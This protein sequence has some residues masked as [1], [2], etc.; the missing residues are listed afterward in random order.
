MK[1]KRLPY[2]KTEAFHYVLTYFENELHV[3]LS[4]IAKAIYE[5]QSK[6]HINFSVNDYYDMLLDILHNSDV[7][8]IAMTMI[9]L[10]RDA[11][12]K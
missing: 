12:Q 11:N 6:Y 1:N 4:D 8:S 3:S 5:T 9:Q 7:L 2:P 10:D